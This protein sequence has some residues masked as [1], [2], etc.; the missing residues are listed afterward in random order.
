MS[1]VNLQE[2]YVT[3]LLVDRA[4]LASAQL[5]GDVLGGYEI[6]L[7][8]YRTDVRPLCA[9]VRADLGAAEDP[10]GTLRNSGYLTRI[11]QARGA[12]HSIG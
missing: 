12:L 10:V 11:A 8:A 5:A 7:D 3:A 2:A 1:V 4:A 9:K 6:L